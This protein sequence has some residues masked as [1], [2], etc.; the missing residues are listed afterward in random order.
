MNTG[1]KMFISFGVG[2]FTGGVGAYFLM[3]EKFSKEAQ[4]A[5]DE[6]REIA[7]NRV[8]AADDF[9][10]EKL[11]EKDQEEYENICDNNHEFIDYTKFS[12]DA[13]VTEKAKNIRD[14][15]NELSKAVNDE[16]FDEH[17]SEREHPEDDEDISDDNLDEINDYEENLARIEEMDAAKANEVAPYFI[18]GS[19][20]HNTKQWYDKISLNYYEGDNTLTDDRDEEIAHN[21]WVNICGEEFYNWFGR[22]E[23]D[24]DI[25]YVRNDQRGIDYEICRV[26]GRY[27]DVS[28]PEIHIS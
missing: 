2:L 13:V 10:K 20:F 3:R 25:V 18:E 7:R 16:S 19:E 26:L 15:L 6:Y 17:F 1:I 11:G 28:M 24:P 14:E 8:R 22:D 27:T 23:D 21:E 5:I 9:V 4:D 12:K